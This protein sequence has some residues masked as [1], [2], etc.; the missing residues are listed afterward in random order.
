[1]P[2]PVCAAAGRTS[3][4]RRESRPASPPGDPP[5]VAHALGDDHPSRAPAGRG[6]SEAV[7][8]RAQH[9]RWTGARAVRLPRSPL[10]VPT[11]TTPPDAA[12]CVSRYR[13]PSGQ[14][15]PYRLQLPSNYDGT[16]PRPLVVQFH[17]WGDGID[18]RPQLLHHGR[19]NGCAA[20]PLG[21]NQA[22]QGLMCPFPSLPLLP[23]GA[24]T[25][26]RRRPPSG[27]STTL[28]F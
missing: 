21:C 15:T 3:P 6:R 27:I 1:M 9:R 5:R 25:V 11:V 2:R 14:Q 13:P 19:D 28:V 24:L 10:S 16:T 22:G 18:Y 20:P 26:F 7:C 4:G 23:P 12:S 8:I 17:G